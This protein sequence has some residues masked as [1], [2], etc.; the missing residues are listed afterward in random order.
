MHCPVLAQE[1]VD[2]EL[3]RRVERAEF[4]RRNY[5]PLAALIAADPNVNPAFAAAV[6]EAAEVAA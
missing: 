2:A 6:V 1:A 5:N 3:H 4:Q